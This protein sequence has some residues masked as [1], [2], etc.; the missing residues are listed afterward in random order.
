MPIR[1]Y[2]QE[3]IQSICKEYELGFNRQIL[4]HAT[5]TGKTYL[6][7]HLPEYTKDLIPAPQ[8][9]VLLHRDELAKQAMEELH[10][11]N[12]KYNIQQDA[13]SIIAD[14]STADVVVSS[15]QTI[16]RSGTKRIQRYDFSKF[17]RIIVDEAHRSV[18]QSYLNV[19]EYAKLLEEGNK[20][21]LLGC[22]ATPTG[23]SDGQG[24]NQVYQKISHTY[25]LRQAI[26]DGW[27][28][29]IRGIRVKTK[30]SLDNVATSGG[31]YDKKELSETVNNPLRN[32]L[33][34]LAYMEHCEG[35]QA[36]GFG[37]DISHSQELAKTFSTYGIKASAVWGN[38]PER[39]IKI[40]NFKLG[41]IQVLFNAQLLVEGFNMPAISCVIMAAPTK[42]SIVFSQRV[43]RGTRI[44]EDKDDCIILDVVDCSSRHSLT[45]LP[46]LLGLPATLDIKGKRLVASVKLLEEE[47]QK[48]PHLDFSE[49][50][51]IDG[52]KTFVEEVNL[53]E[54]KIP[55]E[56]E[57][58]SE[59]IWHPL[60]TGGYV[61][62]LP[63]KESV[64][65]TENVLDKFEIRA[66]IRGKK[67]KGERDS[68]QDAFYAADNLIME[69]A[70]DLL[71]LVK[72][73]AG[74]HNRPASEEQIK[75]I[76]KLFKNK[77]I[78]NDLTSGAASKIIGSVL[79][80]K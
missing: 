21:L 5:G 78:P 16:G 38:D 23:R 7:A 4:C 57:Q 50:T 14:P 59:F 40:K 47:Q 48:Y 58:N 37:V 19:Y 49:L 46:T 71:K 1:P 53:F 52:I 30:T 18:A 33:V 42:S 8:T 2:Q 62:M 39:D 60:L 10:G 54:V 26:E 13:G 28:V 65:I 51:N 20:T 3:A 79:A 69:Q 9:M 24:L 15:V 27:L 34:A 12:P 73:D 45:T 76:K 75:L 44:C 77:Q 35:R 32:S 70:G 55:K 56:V 22:T 17:G 63:N 72:R 31:D 41:N 80:N 61:L 64:R 68:L 74:W 11:I 6:F 25:T 67:F 66:T 36:I 29:D 43:G